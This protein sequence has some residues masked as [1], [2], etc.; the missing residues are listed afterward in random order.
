MGL[1]LQPLSLVQ[2]LVGA[3]GAVIGMGTGLGGTGGRGQE[4]GLGLVSAMPGNGQPSPLLLAWAS[5]AALKE[6]CF[7]W[8]CSWAPVSSRAGR[9]VLDAAVEIA[10][11]ALWSAAGDGW[12]R[13]ATEGRDHRA[14]SSVPCE[15]ARAGQSHWLYF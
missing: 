14:S 1:K 10:R 9:E 3:M 5:L 4:R 12:Q 6:N 13:W 7:S 11:V 2:L 15:S 8:L